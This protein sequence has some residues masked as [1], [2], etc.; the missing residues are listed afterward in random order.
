MH[1]VQIS[2]HILKGSATT[3]SCQ[4]RCFQALFGVQ[5]AQIAG[6]S[7]GSLN[8]DRSFGFWQMQIYLKGFMRS[9]PNAVAQNVSDT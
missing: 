1:L 5:L 9:R 4:R 8:Q 6:R 3:G 2:S 7:S